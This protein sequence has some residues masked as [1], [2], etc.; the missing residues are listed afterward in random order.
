MTV[1]SNTILTMKTSNIINGMLVKI[2]TLKNENKGLKIENRNLFRNYQKLGQ[3][4][5]DSQAEV[6]RL[7]EL[8]VG[9]GGAVKITYSGLT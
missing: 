7:K 8:H 9:C 3:A 5:A 2:Q 6:K 4:L 1:Q